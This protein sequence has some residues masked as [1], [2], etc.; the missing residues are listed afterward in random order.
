[1]EGLIS[2]GVYNRNKKT[3]SKQAINSVDQNT[4]FIYWFLNN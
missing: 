4:F 3:V 1:M 2:E